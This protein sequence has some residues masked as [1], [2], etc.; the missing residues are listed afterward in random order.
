MVLVSLQRMLHTVGFRN[1]QPQLA[2]VAEVLEAVVDST[3]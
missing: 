1:T 2:E 3:K